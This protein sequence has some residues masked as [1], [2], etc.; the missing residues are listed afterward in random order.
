[1]SDYTKLV[2][3]LRMGAD[4]GVEEESV[5]KLCAD[6]AAAIE[7]MAKHITEMHERVTVLQIERGKLETE[8][9]DLKHDIERYVQMNAELL[10]DRPELEEIGGK[11]VWN[12]PKRGDMV[13]V[14]R[15]GE[16]QWYNPLDK[17]RPFLCPVIDLV[18]GVIED[19]YCSR[20][21]RREKMEAQE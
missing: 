7:D 12:D 13:D 10:N 14:V 20:G 11:W 8:V 19:D 18:N 17:S 5:G 3:A 15:C 4:Y 16:C 2:E 6:A 1:M 21:E 9:D